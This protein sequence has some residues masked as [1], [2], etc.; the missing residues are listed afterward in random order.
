MYIKRTV[1]IILINDVTLLK[2]MVNDEYGC[3]ID[4]LIQNGP[5]S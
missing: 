3:K 2:L 5:R 1:D 4:N